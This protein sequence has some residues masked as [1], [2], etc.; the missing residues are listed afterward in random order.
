MTNYEKIKSMN[1]DEMAEFLTNIA[2]GANI[3]A[4][5]HC[6]RKDFKQWLEKETD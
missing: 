4:N 6:I 5:K 1:I 2:V 3:Y